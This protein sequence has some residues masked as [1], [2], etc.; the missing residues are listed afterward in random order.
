MPFR[1]KHIRRVGYALLICLAFVWSDALGALAGI[2][3][4]GFSLERSEVYAHIP[5]SVLEAR[6]KDLEEEMLR[7]RYAGVLLSEEI[8]AH[9]ALVRSLALPEEE[10]V[11]RGRVLARPPGTLY[12]TLIVEPSA[13]AVP[14]VGDRAFVHG[15]LIGAVSETRPLTVALFSSPHTETT[16][17]LGE[18][19]FTATLRGWGGGS[20]TLEAPGDALIHEG[21]VVR[22]EAGSVVAVVAYTVLERERSNMRVYAATPVSFSDMRIVEFV[23]PS[24]P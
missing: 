24:R 6:L 15:F 9:R 14:E 23:R 10:S 7:A 16:V 5:R 2:I 17:T 13:G 8:A 11:Y 19:S 4:H 3:V 22:S 1:F 12:D 18:P 20:F 21:D